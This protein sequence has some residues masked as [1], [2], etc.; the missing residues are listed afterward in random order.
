M[1][2]CPSR[3]PRSRLAPHLSHLHPSASVVLAQTTHG[4]VWSWHWIQ[5]KE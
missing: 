5:G 1:V 3:D 4:I 2:I